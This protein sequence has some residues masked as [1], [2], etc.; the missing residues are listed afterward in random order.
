M[1]DPSVFCLV[2]EG[3]VLVHRHVHT[4]YRDIYKEG[5]YAINVGVDVWSFEP[6]PM[7]KILEIVKGEEED[8]L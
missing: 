3:G 7:D 6:V 1:H 4:L 5:K 2:P 8:D